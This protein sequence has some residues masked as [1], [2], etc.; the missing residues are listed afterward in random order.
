MQMPYTTK[1]DL[2]STPYRNE[3]QVHESRVVRYHSSS[4][5][6]GSPTVMAYTQ[7]D[8]DLLGKLTA[9]AFQPLR[10]R[11]SH[12]RV[13]NAF[14]YGLFTGGLSFEEAARHAREHMN[15][16]MSV[17]PASN[18]PGVSFDAA[19]AQHRRS[20]E[21]FE[22]TILCCTPSLAFALWEEGLLDGF[23]A[24]I[25]G[26]EPSSAGLRK[27]LEGRGERTVIEVY[28]L[29]EVIGPG[30]AQSCEHGTLHLNEDAF[31]AEFLGH[32]LVLTT[33]HN[34]AMPRSRYRTGDAATPVSCSCDNPHQAIQVFGREGDF[35]P[36]LGLYLSE[37][38]ELLVS[39]G[40][41]P[42]FRLAERALLVEPLPHTRARPLPPMPIAV[43]QVL[44]HTHPRSLG[45]SSRVAPSRRRQRESF[46]Q[47]PAH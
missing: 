10:A 5:S 29:S 39:H 38:E 17:I 35:I 24:I 15:I 36:A 41:S 7:A 34:Q 4:G 42:C 32:E 20:I 14:G 31:D 27:I 30:V 12:W 23:E 19:M 25:T 28:G 21:L 18:Q 33:R 46:N 43:R 8:L 40:Y 2:R 3:L 45:K 16:P 13:Y 26:G 9:R 47:A 44:P 22:P 37:L 1:D 11:V 6:T